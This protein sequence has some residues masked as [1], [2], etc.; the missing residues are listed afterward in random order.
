MLLGFY[1]VDFV[2]LRGMQIS[3]RA[4]LVSLLALAG[5]LV[6]TA[7][8]QAARSVPFE[9]AWELEISGLNMSSSP[10]IADIDS[11]GRNEI[12]F[13]HRDGKLRAYEADGS[14]KWE[15]PAVPGASQEP[16]QQQF[17]PSAIDSSPAVADIDGDGVFEVIVGVGSASAG[18]RDQN[19]SVIA[20]DGRTGRIEWTFKQSRDTGNIWDGATPELD[21]WCEATYATPAIGDVDGNGAV[22]IVFGSYDFYIWAIDG[23]GNPLPGF[24]LNN[25]DTIWSSPALFDVDND[26][27][28]EIFIGGDSTPAGYVDHLGGIFRAI[29]Y[30]DGAPVIT[31]TREANDVFHSSPA[32]GDINGDGRFEAVTGTGDNWFIECKQRG[33]QLCGPNDGSDN[34]KV[35]AFHLDD[36]SD[37]AGWP[38]SAGGTVWSSP[39]IG[40][41]D[42]DGQPEVVVG[43][44]DKRVY[45]WNGDGSLQWSTKPQF[46]HLGDGDLV[47][48]SPVIA[49]LDGDADQDV[50]IGTSKG[51]AL[52]DGRTGSELEANV[53]WKGR[54]SF[55]YSHQTAPAVGELNGERVIVFVA[56]FPDLTKTR[57]AAYKLPPSATRDAWPMF[58]HGPTRLGTASISRSGHAALARKPTVG[59]TPF[60]T[61][62]V[63][64]M[65]G[66]DIIDAG[67]SPCVT[68][69]TPTTR[70]ETALYMWRMEDRPTAAPHPF[71]D[72]LGRELN[73]AVAW[74]YESGVTTGKVA[75]SGAFFAPDDRLTR[76]EVA[77]FLYR[78]AGEPEASDHPFT[79]VT[80][81]WQQE[82]VAWLSTTGITT[83]TSPTTFS[84]NLP[85]TRGELATFLY[86][87]KH[88]PPVTIDPASPDCSPAAA[89]ATAHWTA[90]TAG[91]KHTCGLRADGTIK[92]WGDNRH[93]Q[94]NPPA[95]QFTAVSAGNWYSCGLRAGGTIKCWGDN[96][97]GQLNAPAGQFKTV[98]ASNSYSCGLRAGGTIKCWGDNSQGQ[99]N[100]PAEQFKTVSTG[101]FHACGLS[102][103]G[104]VHCWGFN[105]YELEGQFEAVSVGDRH[106]CG[107]R[108]N[109]TIE[110]W[111]DNN[112]HGQ[113]NPPSGQFKA[114]SA[115][116]WYTCGLLTNGTIKCWGTNSHGQR[117]A[118]SG[119][120][121]AVT[122]SIFHSCAISTTIECWGDIGY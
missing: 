111:G 50:A 112:S 85:V 53:Y 64:W 121:N 66:T 95:G 91:Q 1:S 9:K 70:G 117:N 25:D 33:N 97:Q 90:V 19:G 76:A 71:S 21:G 32:I 42:A 82:P 44:D 8:A 114:V 99:L 41:V 54:M 103:E 48:G 116:N 92:C 60:F 109:G 118:P 94:S 88:E 49:D 75:D 98:S 12:V 37:V 11:D 7:P 101:L 120:F 22:D 80:A 35:W 63:Q 62:P 65:V 72:V 87:Y 86:R 68:P 81:P 10:V 57:V 15:A 20:F 83:G 47:R 3:L 104:T 23:S 113:Q 13:G 58:R 38:V 105:S 89:T 36:G 100:A 108:S 119:Q 27:D 73:R 61:K 69:N 59:P 16:C 6:A 115:G 79:D 78:H 24:P 28:V 110:C 34:S 5:V 77:A 93:G 74:M 39:S 56:N 40:D 29:D 30:R 122:T 14:L 51:L 96:S 45:A 107:L 102:T 2:R 31:W 52:L 55:A 18:A 67:A 43:S 46:A 17:T 4:S 106:T 26:G 84:P